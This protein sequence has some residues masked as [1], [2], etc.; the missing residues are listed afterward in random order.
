MKLPLAILF[1]LTGC[2]ARPNIPQPADLEVQSSA[3]PQVVPTIYHFGM[4]WNYIPYAGDE[5]RPVAFN[6]WASNDLLNWEYV[7][8]TTNTEY[9]AESVHPIEFYNVSSFFP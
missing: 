2:A 6:V 5:N 3:Q 4:A 9:V 1:F 7:D 8:T